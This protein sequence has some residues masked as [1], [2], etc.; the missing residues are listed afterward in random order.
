MKAFTLPSSSCGLVNLSTRDPEQ[1]HIQ[2]HPHTARLKGMRKKVLARARL[3]T[4]AHLAGGFRRYCV[5][6]TTT[7]AADQ[8]Y[9][10]NDIKQLTKR[11]TKHARKEG[12]ELPFVWVQELQKRGAPHYHI[13]VWLPSGMILPKPDKAGWWTKGSTRIE[14]AHKPVNYIS[15]YTSKGATHDSLAIMPKGARMHGFGGFEVAEREVLRWHA[16]PSWLK[17]QIGF[18][19]AKRC[20]GGGWVNPETGEWFKSPYRVWFDGCFLHIVLK[21]EQC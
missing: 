16:M 14:A 7:Y 19:V 2:L 11:I 17:E 1:S 8:T 5:M 21:E 18:V 12:V 9:A 3:A 13:L 6:I 20:V 4:K 15:K 10:P